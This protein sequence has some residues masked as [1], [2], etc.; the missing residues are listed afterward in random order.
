MAAAAAPSPPAPAL[1]ARFYDGAGAWWLLMTD[2][3]LHSAVI[4]R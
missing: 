4:G 3:L 1:P 2:L